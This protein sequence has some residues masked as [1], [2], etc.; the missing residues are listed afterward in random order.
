M[1]DLTKKEMTLPSQ[2]EFDALKQRVAKLENDLKALKKY[3]M[4]YQKDQTVVIKS[5]IDRHEMP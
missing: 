2:E 5:H 1:Y 3:Y 4:V